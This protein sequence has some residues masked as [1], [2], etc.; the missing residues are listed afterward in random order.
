MTK[1]PDFNVITVPEDTPPETVNDLVKDGW[2][3]RLKHHTQSY[4]GSSD[5]SESCVEES[6]HRGS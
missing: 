5:R 2:I 1:E 4:S 6:P 3:V